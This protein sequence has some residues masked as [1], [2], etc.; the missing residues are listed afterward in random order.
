MIIKDIENLSPSFIDDY[1]KTIGKNIK[2][3]RENRKISQLQLSQAIGFK[4]VGLVSQAELYLS[5]Q[6]FNIGGFD[7]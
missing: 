6:H 7:S 5:K 1:Y 2:R 4:S 3:I